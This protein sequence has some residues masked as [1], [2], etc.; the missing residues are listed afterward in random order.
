[1]TISTDLSFMLQDQQRPNSATESQC[2]VDTVQAVKRKR[3][4]IPTE[5]LTEKQIQRVLKNRISANRSREK[6]QKRLDELEEENKKLRKDNQ[7]LQN[8]LSLLEAKVNFLLNSGSVPGATGLYDDLPLENG[9]LRKNMLME[10]GVAD[11]FTHAEEENGEI[12][13]DYND[14][15]TQE[16]CG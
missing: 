14:W 6:K 1:M 11:T 5:N 13:V 7:Q 4:R 9:F 12:S 2:S 3:G 16:W 10:C 8:R 15:L